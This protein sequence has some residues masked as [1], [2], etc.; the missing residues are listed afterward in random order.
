M[1]NI[2]DFNFSDFKRLV[3]CFCETVFN[4]Q[5]RRNC[6]CILTAGVENNVSYWLIQ[7]SW[8][9]T[10]GEG[11]FFK[12]RRGTDEC[13]IESYG[14]VVVQPV[15]PTTCPNSVCKNGA[16]TLKDCSCKCNGGWTGPRCDL[17]SLAC[18]NGG[19]VSEGCVSCVCPLGFSGTNCEGGFSVT[20]LASCVGSSATITISYNFVGTA[21]GN[22]YLHEQFFKL[23]KIILQL[24]TYNLLELLHALD[25]YVS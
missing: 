17:C 3:I 19:T 7:N 25:Y 4:Q 8:G 10:F 16:T 12:I 1:S 2:N 22:T 18:Q 20:P 5:T 24:K 23:L 15:S 9:S 11:G 14:L 6:F 21:V 13:N